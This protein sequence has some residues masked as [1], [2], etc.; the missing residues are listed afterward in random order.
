[1]GFIAYNKSLIL[2]F[3]SLLCLS[4]LNASVYKTYS[5]W[6]IDALFV[7]WLINRHV[8]KESEF[9]IVEKGA[10]IEPEYAINTPDSRF[11][12]GG[13][14]TAF[15]SALRQLNIHTSCTDSLTPIIRII[16]LAPWRKAEYIHVLTFESDIITLL[17][18]QDISAVFS[19]IDEY[20]KG[21]KK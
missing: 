1:M 7:A 20:C 4:S 14:E 8:D 10:F 5:Q 21:E 2:L 9:I 15:E 16:E 3:L 12:R 11:R 13:K 19:Y 18:K 17:N 6:E